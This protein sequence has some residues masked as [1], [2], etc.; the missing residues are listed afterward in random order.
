M[1][2]LIL[3]PLIKRQDLNLA[4]IQLL[5][6]DW[7]KSEG[8]RMHSQ[9]KSCRSEP[10]MAF[11]LIDRSGEIEK[12]I[13]H[14]RLCPLPNKKGA[15]WIESVIV[16][17]NDRGKGL[18]KFLM[19]QLEDFIRSFGYTEIYLSTEDKQFFYER[20]GY[21]TCQSIVH[22]TA[23]PSMLNL[24]NRLGNVEET[25][26][27]ERK[28]VISQEATESTKT[29]IPTPPPPPPSFTKIKPETQLETTIYMKKSLH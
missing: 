21:T 25:R 29:S 28:P 14:A 27:D 2:N 4:C 10:P 12:L 23:A 8:S 26:I 1:E 19:I 16:D 3:L 9:E 7:P 18:G 11:L 5:N 13:G 22:T 15:C 6:Q 20:C 24:I 17:K